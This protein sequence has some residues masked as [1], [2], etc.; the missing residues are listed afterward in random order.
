M[1]PA[2][3]VLVLALAGLSTVGAQNGGALADGG[4]EIAAVDMRARTAIG[5]HLP[6]CAGFDATLGASSTGLVY[7]ADVYPFGLVLP[8]PGIGGGRGWLTA[9]AG[10]GM[11]GVRG[12]I[13]FGR[14][15]PGALSAQVPLGPVVLGLWGHAA[16][17]ANAEP[18]RDGTEATAGFADE[19]S[20]GFEIRFGRPRDSDGL[21]LPG[22]VPVVGFRHGEVMG[23]HLSG[24][25]V[26]LGAAASP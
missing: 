2:R 16:L 17:V 5:Y 18:R 15:F 23:S 12:S 9:C 19:Y 13:P 8:S 10:F 21:I 4:L 1:K 25:Y 11:S 14:E 26:G 20:A 6:T 22:G 3:G 24:V 7:G